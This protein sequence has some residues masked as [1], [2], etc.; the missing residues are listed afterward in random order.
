MLLHF[1]STERKK[2]F[3]LAFGT[4]KSLIGGSEMNPFP[5]PRMTVAVCD[6]QPIVIEGLRAVLSLSASYRLLEPSRNL[7]S[8]AHVLVTLSPR[9]AM[10]D[11]SLGNLELIEWLTRSRLR[12]S[13]AVIV[14][15]ASFTESE[16]LRFLQAGARGVLRK[17]ARLDTLTACLEAVSNGATWMDDNL[18]HAAGGYGVYGR[19]EL[20]AREQQVLELV[21]QGMRN[22]EIAHELGIRPGTVK[23]HLKHIFEKSGV[24]GRFG[25]ALSGFRGHVPPHY[26]SEKLSA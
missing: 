6:T 4:P 25:L 9:A 13:T 2:I 20:T 18:F 1:Q 26:T 17:T 10:V 21:E 8:L 22:K 12:G 7:E 15:G 3:K 19:T 11:K 24:R 16:A 14:W 23:I 5:D